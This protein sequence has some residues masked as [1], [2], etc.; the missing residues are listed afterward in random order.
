MAEKTW[1]IQEQVPDAI[2]QKFSEMHPM[3]VQLMWNRGIKDQSEIDQFLN[4]DYEKDLHDPFLFL[5]MHRA[6]DRIFKAVEDGESIMIHG[7]YDGDGICGTAIILSAIREVCERGGFTAFD[8]GRVRWYL[9]DREGDGYGLSHKT[10]EEF[11]ND[12]V[13]LIIT[14]DCGIANTQEI[15]LAYKYGM[16]VIVVDHHQIPDVLPE[17]AM[18]IHPLV[19]G[20]T[21]P[22][23]K[24]AA[25]GVAYKVACAMYSVARDRGIYIPDGLEKWL[26]DLVA[27]ATVTDMVPLVGENRMLEK[28]GLV[29]LNR[30]KRTGL[31]ALMEAAGLE[32]GKLNTTDIGFRIGPRINAAGR[33]ANAGEALRAILEDGPVAARHLANRL[34]EINK[35]RQKLTG[36]ATKV[37]MTSIEGEDKRFIAVVDNSI[38]IGIAGLVAGQIANETG[39]PAVVMTKVNDHFVGSGR[40]PKG[41]HFLEAMD[42]CRDMM[43]AGGGHPQACGFKL[44]ESSISGW[45]EAMNKHA[46]KTLDTERGPELNIDAELDLA[47]ANIELVELVQKM[48]PY[49]VGNELPIFVSRGVRVVSAESIGKSKTHLRLT[50]AT[51]EHVTRKCIGFGYGKWSNLLVMGDTIDIVYEV[52]VNEWNGNRELQ[53]Q[54]KDIKKI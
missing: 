36:S 38:R 39:L 23:K 51:D 18:L 5:N 41:F 31:L 52:G 20:E 29:V 28:Y 26:L 7:D 17:K 47:L 24:L 14:V 40:G 8:D 43:V 35:E 13:D 4:P 19:S 12:G 25:V 10:V 16:E 46:I 54:I 32:L 37:A 15:A 48:E 6:V 44:E 53:L 27:I 22:F 11:K 33:I 42:T 1:V 49:G 9:P 2:A 34:G 50:I 45:V 21:Y 30:T 3:L